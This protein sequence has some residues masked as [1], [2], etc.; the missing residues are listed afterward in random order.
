MGLL[1]TTMLTLS[2]GALAVAGIPGAT[3]APPSQLT[4]AKQAATSRSAA[5]VD[6]R[7]QVATVTLLTGD[8][9]RLTT[10]PGGVITAVPMHGPGRDGIAFS[11]RRH[12]SE[13]EVLPSDAAPLVASGKLD[14]RL[15]EIA[16]LVR[17]GYD[18][19]K[20]T[21]IPL[22]I[23]SAGERVSALAAPS[24]VAVRRSLPSVGASALVTQKSSA[25]QFWR[26]LAGPMANSR[27]ES[28]VRSQQTLASG[29]Q[30]V[31]LDGPVRETLDRSVPQTGAPR[32]WKLGY[33]G[34]GVKVAV[35]DSGIDKTHPDLAGAVVAERNFST[36]PVVTDR[37]GHG[38]HVASTITGSGAASKGR[39]KGMAPDAT[40]V[41]AK[42][43]DDTGA[44]TESRL[45]AGMEWAADQGV[46]VANISVGSTFPTDGTDPIATALNRISAQKRTLFVVA[47]GNLGP[48]NQMITSPGS[49]DAALTVG[50]VDAKGATAEFSSRGPRSGDLALKPEI[51]APGVGIVAARARQSTPDE[52]V[53]DSYA[54][55]SGTSMAAPHVTGGAALLAQLRPTWTPAQLKAL[56]ISTA[57]PL[58][59]ESAVA[60]GAGQLDPGRALT[61]RVNVEEGS[62]SLFMRWPHDSVTTRK[63]TYRNTTASD[64]TLQIGVQVHESVGG[65]PAPA[66]LIR[67]GAKTL[68]VPARSTAQVTVIADPKVALTDVTY[69]GRITATGPGIAVQTPFTLG[70]ESESYD[71]TIRAIDLNGKLVTSLSQLQPA[72][73]VVGDLQTGDLYT[74][75]ATAKGLVARV[76]RG[77][78]T[79]G[80]I[81]ATPAGIKPTAYT[82]LSAPRIDVQG[83]S[84]TVTLDAR[85]AKLVRTQ[86]DA[87]DATPN[88]TIFGTVEVLGGW[89]FTTLLTLEGPHRNPLYALPTTQVTG[90]TYQFAMFRSLESSRGTYDLTFGNEGR[91]PTSPTYTVR[92]AD[93]SRMNVSFATAGAAL[94]LNGV[95]HREAQL[96]GDS[97][98]GL[99][100]YYDLPLPSNRTHLF[101]PAFA[102]KPLPWT[103]NL[104]VRT[105]I[106]QVWYTEFHDPVVYEPGQVVDRTFTPAA[107]RPEVKG[108]RHSDGTMSFQMSPLA[109]SLRG[110]SLM[111]WNPTGVDGTSTLRRN[112]KVV[113]TSTDPFTLEVGGQPRTSADYTLDVTAKVAV[114]WARYA[115]E[116]NGHWAFTS[117]APADYVEQITML[118][119]LVLGT[120]DGSGRAPSGRAFRL[121]LPIMRP[122]GQGTIRDVSLSVSYDDGRTWAKAPV[123]QDSNG[124]WA[125]EIRHP[126]KPGGYVSIRTS[127]A[128]DRGG[129]L[130]VTSIRAYGLS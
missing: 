82:L 113:A 73:A 62:L 32:A 53:G 66:G 116:V 80:T 21:Q 17:A 59:G 100:W 31:W 15:F 35:I 89:P 77:T 8:R 121:G 49:A 126:N 9:V 13:I 2:A 86:V 128:D 97:T 74:L 55:M 34:K 7:K 42:V 96:P 6:H 61:Q 3:A 92:D 29:V 88:L 39:Y 118:N 105:T 98:M 12:G 120:F 112:G 20:T 123:G 129:Q 125:A 65:G 114:P 44:G 68:R 87:P 43:L 83:A 90:R 19:A 91:V 46:K 1:R 115:T 36:S 30:Q 25:A 37:N 58:A 93:L 11:T 41:S 107:F 28:T 16:G 40:L 57:K 108:F 119:S 64:A 33:T 56:L 22:I 27:P 26:W 70:A 10:A 99:G 111:I 63:L 79:F 124:N 106:S 127:A 23:R 85:Q 104:D 84:R 130:T 103:D 69:D 122:G 48:D 4:V 76:P 72:P 54:R 81:V 117:A 95:W 102:G 14:R 78:Y 71:V 52:P 50:A 38:T 94:N 67:V 5:P 75:R 45:I 60:Q 47:A 101:T 110:G 24:G 18:D 109:P 51:A